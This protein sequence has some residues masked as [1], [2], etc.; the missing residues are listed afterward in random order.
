MLDLFLPGDTWESLLN[1]FWRVVD[2]FDLAAMTDLFII[3]KSETTF[4]V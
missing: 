4:F 1:T 2:F 3:V